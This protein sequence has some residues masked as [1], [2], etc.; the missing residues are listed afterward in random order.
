MAAHSEMKLCVFV[1]NTGAHPAG[2][3]LPGSGANRMHDFDFYRDLALTAERGKFDVFFSGDAQGYQHIEGRETFAGTDNG[4]KLEPLT[5]L[6]ALAVTTAN[7]GLVG[8]ASTTYNEPY[9]LARRFA[10][11]DHLSGG[12]AGWNVVTSTTNSEARNFGRDV[13][14]DHDQRYERAEEFVD[15]VRGLWDSWEDDAFLYDR[16]GGRFFNPDKV[17]ALG[18]QGRF[19]KVEGPL[20]I[21]RPPQGH[22]ILV[23]AGASGPGRQLSARA[24]DMIFTA[25]PSLEKAQTFYAEIKAAAQAFGRRPE[26]VYVIPSVQPLV[27]ST[28]VEARRA[29]EE[30]QDL[31]P[32]G[33]ALSRLQ[34]LLGGFDLSK[35]D[36][37][38]PLPEVPATNGGQWVQSQILEMARREKLSIWELAK[39]AS[40]SRSSFNLVCSAE[41]A[42]DIL[43]QWYREGAADG[44]S[45]TP[46]SLPEGLTDFVDQVVPILRKR[47]LV[48][49]DYRAATLRENL[50]LPTPAN[51]FRE[52][53][54]RHVEPAM[55][56]PVAEQRGGE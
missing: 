39:R 21:G 25:Q 18:H 40:V 16:Q 47:G 51:Y 45:L 44:F 14:M 35:F 37:D 4:G 2:W 52:H 9:A 32:R 12:R 55:W 56:A 49:T 27:K 48:K 23:Q 11:L 43:E 54:E 26:H 7:I 36:P 30:L 34:M 19:F 41:R 33:L 29:Y 6:S 17:H 20:N 1:H 10:S 3:R 13:N 22:P 42:A 8:T 28:E 53:P 50:G 24:A 31:M 5:L 46:A 38:G 15:V